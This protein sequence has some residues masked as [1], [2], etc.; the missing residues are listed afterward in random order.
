MA[1]ETSTALLFPEAWGSLSASHPRHLVVAD[2]NALFQDTL[3]RATDG[4]TAMTF[5][6]ERGSITLLSAA[7]VPAK[8]QEHLPE[9]AADAGISEELVMGT[10]RTVHEPLTRFVSVPASLCA[11]DLRVAAVRDPEDVAFA[12][13]AVAVGPSLLLTRDHHLHNAGIGTEQWVETLLILGSLIELE[14]VFFGSTKLALACGY[15][16]AKMAVEGVR[17]LCRSPVAFGV[18]LG[19]GVLLVS[20]DRQSLARHTTKARQSL[21]TA[22]S[23][24]LDLVAPHFERRLEAQAHLGTTLVAPM[25][26]SSAESICA[27]ELAIS[28]R[29]LGAADLLLP[30]RRAGYDYALADLESKLA[31]HP[32]FIPEGEGTWV[33][34]GSPKKPNL[35]RKISSQ[36]AR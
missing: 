34:G 14:L 11:K 33:L 19:A 16:L 10:W 28:S 27:R 20:Q 12:Q 26:P 24:A 13:L 15:L 3:R 21:A 7:H 2:A 23:R 31:A 35:T 1:G 8:A 32:S 9:M 5:L 36:A 18:A 30:L 6:A 17:F 25:D 22:S 4:F 29:G